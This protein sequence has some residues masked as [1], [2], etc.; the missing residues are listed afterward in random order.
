MNNIG[1]RI[2]QLRKEN[3]LT[4]EKL[5]DYLGIS[6]K[7]VSKWETGITFPDLSMIVPISKL[8]GVSTDELLGVKN[9]VPDERKGFF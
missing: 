7:S 3:D 1:K 8:L 9:E 5:A 6:Y 2:K 4:Q